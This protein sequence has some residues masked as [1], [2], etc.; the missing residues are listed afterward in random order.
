[1]RTGSAGTAPNLQGAAGRHAVGARRPVRRAG[2]RPQAIRGSPDREKSPAPG[3]D[4]T[5]PAVD[6]SAL[7]AD[8]AEGPI[9]VRGSGD[10]YVDVT[11]TIPRCARARPE[12]KPPPIQQ[13][14]SGVTAARP[15]GSPDRNP[16]PTP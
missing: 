10:C 13:E 2:T 8:P 11:G 15:A 1:A 16:P 5:G 6:P 14:A 9:L 3:P 4:Q 7:T 12:R